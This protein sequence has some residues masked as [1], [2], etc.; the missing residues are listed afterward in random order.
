MT[1]IFRFALLGL[2]AGALYT[3]VAQGLIVVY[4]GSG[5]LNFAQGAVGVAGAYAYY[6]LRVEHSQGFVV[7]FAGGILFSVL[8]GVLTQVLIMRRLRTASPLARVVATLGVLIVIQSFATIR[9]GGAT[10]TVPNELPTTRV[11]IFGVA[12]SADRLY[13][14]AIAALLTIV[15][16]L[17]YRRTRFGLMTAAVA[18]NERT[19]SSI[20]LSPSTIAVTNWAIGSG[21]AG[22]AAILVAPIIG[23]QPAAMT[24]L[25]LSA[26]AVA[27]VA[28]FSSF[29]LA[30]LAGS[31]LGIAESELLQYVSTP[32]LA[33]S[34]PFFVIVVLVAI[35]GES[36]PLRDFFLQKLPSV[37]TGQIRWRLLG[38]AVG[39]TVLV[40]LVADPTWNL[41]ITNTLAPAVIVL[42]IIVVTGY[43][44][45]LS[46]AQ[47]AIGGFG[48]WVAGRLVATSGIDLMPAMLI[49]VAA[50]VPLGAIFALPALRARG[51]QLAIVTLGLGTAI[52][53]M[54]FNNGDLV[55]GFEGTIVGEPT[56]LGIDVTQS[57]Y[58]E[59]YSLLCLACLV[60]LVLSVASVRRGRVGRRLLAART[61]ER[62]AAAIGVSVL[63][64]KVYAFALSA[65]IAAVGSILVAF[66]LFVIA[67]D[68]SFTP[69]ASISAV[70]WAFIG[71]IGYLAGSVFGAFIAPGSVVAH[72]MDELLPG[73]SD[74][75][76]V[77][78]GI[79]VIGL[80]LGNQDGMARETQRQLAWLGKRIVRL[81]PPLGR[82]RAGPL[83]APVL[84]P[85]GEVRVAR[86]TLLVE[87]V[88]VRYGAVTA[89]NEL[90]LAIRPGEI[91]GLIG[92]NGAGKTTVIDA[93]SGF[94]APTAGRILLDGADITATAPAR[95]A[96]MGISRS[97]QSLELFEDA[98][99]L[100]NLESAW[101]P[102]DRLSYL[103]DLVFPRKVAMP[104]EVAAAVREFG[105]AG[106]LMKP[107]SDLPYGRRRLVAI[108]RALATRPSVLL[109]DE[110]AAG[111]SEVE[112]RELAVLVRRLAVDWGI[113]VLVVEHD[114]SFVMEVSD[115]LVVIDFGTRIAAGLPEQVRSDAHV[116]AVYLGE[117]EDE[118]EDAP[119]LDRVPE[120]NRT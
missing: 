14:I 103:T 15:L 27:L 71:G 79:A 91:V 62:A 24:A 20:G 28:N 19:A 23:L 37:G 4:R 97:F 53:L 66:Q 33:T 113:A 75:L 58:P 118:D 77:I 39:L 41:A 40:I 5:V 59:R 45:Q 54:I 10:T 82:L 68:S 49:G 16:H 60:L 111:L 78:G 44:G 101:E 115:Q 22:M 104:P 63:E 73:L 55:G 106:D 67:Y 119:M 32:G 107:V 86:R 50:A 83:S 105:L 46:L 35:K 89:V 88:T 112:T 7:A 64:A 17:V 8:V 102:R 25:A 84:P 69:L 81:V 110:P 38:V 18:E 2:G 9:Y 100:E 85:G 90:S 114:M 43:A 120:E 29:G 21:L 94:T 34:L 76:G 31:L 95:R 116:I 30:L 12:T 3:L 48:A 98:T 96:R 108:A 57:S 70:A 92:P 117:D 56:F 51:V 87:G 93:L 65:G 72:A 6:E 26:M 61:N 11:H 52:N 109:L 42:S 99:V 36:I 47:F 13:I 74:Y 80:A 1:E